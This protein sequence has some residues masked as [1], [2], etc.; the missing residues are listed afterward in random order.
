[1]L[2]GVMPFFGCLNEGVV[3]ASYPG[4]QKISLSSVNG[5]EAL[6]LCRPDH[7]LQHIPVPLGQVRSLHH[8]HVNVFTENRS[9]PSLEVLGD[10]GSP[11]HLSSGPP[12]KEVPA[13]W[14]SRLDLDNE[15]LIWRDDL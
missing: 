6:R 1:M 8:E 11:T 12:L 13:R 3:T 2:L 5:R 4:A 15:W 9:L 14:Q 7:T 10:G